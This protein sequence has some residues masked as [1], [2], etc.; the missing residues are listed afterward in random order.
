MKSFEFSSES[1][2]VCEIVYEHFPNF[3]LLWLIKIS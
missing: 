1:P 3:F 2:W